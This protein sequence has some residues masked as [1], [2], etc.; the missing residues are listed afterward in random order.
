MKSE[1]EKNLRVLP[2]IFSGS[3]SRKS[4]PLS[5]AHEVGNEISSNKAMSTPSLYETN[6][7]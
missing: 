2:G 5:N 7:K 6:S 3:V 4:Y 1:V